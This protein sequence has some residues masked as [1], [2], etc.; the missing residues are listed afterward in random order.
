MIRIISENVSDVDSSRC[1]VCSPLL[2]SQFLQI[3]STKIKRIYRTMTLEEIYGETR[4]DC[5]A[6]VR[7]FHINF[8]N[9]P[10]L[11]PQIFLSFGKS[12]WS[13]FFKSRD[14]SWDK[15]GRCVWLTTYHTCSAER[16]ENSGP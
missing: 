6:H 3:H 5:G 13:I 15:G 7:N 8:P 11:E 2:E 9:T 16:Q 4:W 1:I 10:V 12:H 14:F